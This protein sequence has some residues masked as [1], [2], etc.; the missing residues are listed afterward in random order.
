MLFR[1]GTPSY[2]PR[3]RDRNLSRYNRS[4]TGMADE[5]IAREDGVKVETVRASIR[6]IQQE[7]LLHAPEFATEA[8][9]GAIVD[10]KEELKRAMRNGLTATKEYFDHQTNT[11]TTL[12]DVELQLQAVDKVAKLATAIQKKETR[13]Q[14]QVNVGLAVGAKPAAG[15]YIGVEDR[16]RKLNE[17]REARLQLQA[18]EEHEVVAPPEEGEEQE[19]SV[20]SR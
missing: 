2:S 20:D 19:F 17:A 15:G 3:S 10:T 4:R 9:V 1:S 13:N 7:R 14:T 11:S 8:I 16:I 6:A 18:G 12:P 5:D